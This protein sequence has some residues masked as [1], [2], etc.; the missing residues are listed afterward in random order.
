[1]QSTDGSLSHP[2]D[3]GALQGSSHHFHFTSSIR[4]GLFFGIWTSFSGSIALVISLV[5]LVP[6]G[7]ILLGI[8]KITIRMP[9]NLVCS[10]SFIGTGFYLIMSSRWRPAVHWLP[11]QWSLPP[12]SCSFVVWSLGG[13]RW[14]VTLREGHCT[15]WSR[16]LKKPVQLS[17]QTSS[18]QAL[19]FARWFKI[20][21]F[22]YFVIFGFCL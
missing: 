2:V 9:F 15:S 17:H 7:R 8:C 10:F 6:I 11:T 21:F 1:M 14:P 16:P 4:C 3:V 12:D 5:N 19:Y 22:N 20:F 13:N 18:N